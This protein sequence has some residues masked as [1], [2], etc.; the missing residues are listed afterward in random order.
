MRIAIAGLPALACLL[1]G[2][3]DLNPYTRP[4]VWEPLGA[5]ASNL[6]AMAAD[7][8][9]LEQGKPSA[10]SSGDAAAAAVAR[11]RA[12][13]VRR[14]PASAISDLHATEPGPDYPPA[15]GTPTPAAPEAAP[16]AVPGVAQ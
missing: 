8:H 14:L 9:D 6:R 3:V 2:C 4:G 16:T 1:A 5:N 15:A 11:L 13:A 10:P 12:D 7:P